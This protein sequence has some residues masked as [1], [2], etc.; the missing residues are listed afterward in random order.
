MLNSK[1]NLSLSWDTALCVGK[2][3]P[4]YREHDQVKKYPQSAGLNLWVQ[5]KI[6]DPDEDVIVDVDPIGP[7]RIGLS[8]MPDIDF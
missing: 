4:Y 6:I 3:P 8:S 2:I 1:H 5:A 7:L